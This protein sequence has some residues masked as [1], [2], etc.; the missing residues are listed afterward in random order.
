MIFFRQI[1]WPVT[2]V[3]CR[4]L[5]L[6]SIHYRCI[7]TNLCPDLMRACLS[8]VLMIVNLDTDRSSMSCPCDVIYG[9]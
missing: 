1:G 4:G 8:R 9:Q 3:S 6:L 7:V 2:L 5:G